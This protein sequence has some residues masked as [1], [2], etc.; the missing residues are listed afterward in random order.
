MIN[1]TAPRQQRLPTELILTIFEHAEANQFAKL[2]TI[3][4][5]LRSLLLSRLFQAAHLHSFAEVERLIIQG[6]PNITLPN[7]DLINPN[8]NTKLALYLQFL[9]FS[10]YS[11]SHY[12]RLIDCL[13]HLSKSIRN[14][15]DTL[16]FSTLQDSSLGEEVILGL[17]M[18]NF[19]PNL[20]RLYV[21]ATS[22]PHIEEGKEG[23]QDQ[24]MEAV[25]GHLHYE[26]LPLEAYALAGVANG[27]TD[28]VF[29]QRKGLLALKGQ[30]KT[31]FPSLQRLNLFDVKSELPSEPPGEDSQ[32]ELMKL[33]MAFTLETEVKVFAIIEVSKGMGKD[34]CAPPA[35]VLFLP[36]GLMVFVNI[37]VEEPKAGHE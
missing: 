30:Y 18:L 12:E 9:Y 13:Q 10:E 20:K 14:K 33:A 31:I 26:S 36:M 29:S 8:T 19:F 6:W 32:D 5:A 2:S 21:D 7:G 23:L 37:C 35:D 24:P 25:L 16:G 17:W 1:P 4:K 3:N 11:E 15:V 22:L 27:N 28:G 34:W